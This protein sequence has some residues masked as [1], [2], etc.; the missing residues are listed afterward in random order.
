MIEL[1]LTFICIIFPFVGK[2]IFEYFYATFLD[3][4]LFGLNSFEYFFTIYPFIITTLK[5]IKVI[6]LM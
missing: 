4:L 6:Y 2:K 3:T 1:L 5:K